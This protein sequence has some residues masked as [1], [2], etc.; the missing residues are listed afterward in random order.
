MLE[1]FHPDVRVL[2]RHPGAPS[3]EVTAFRRRHPG[4]PDTVV[5]LMREAT[6][7]ELAYRGRYLRLYGPATAA[8]MDEAYSISRRI[9]GAV[10]IGDNGGGEAIIIL[11]N[12]R[13]IHRV[14]YGAL[15]AD[16]V[17]PVAGDLEELLVAATVPAEA[18]G[19]VLA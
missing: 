3:S 12:G 7:L 11:E 17:L 4:L 16:E 6:D 10:V 1:R 8:E 19:S 15:D 5:E 2:A 18:V 13:G 9:P 14:G